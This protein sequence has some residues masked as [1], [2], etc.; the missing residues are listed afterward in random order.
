VSGASG[1]DP[2]RS[3]RTPFASMKSLMARMRSE[4]GFALLEAIVSA[5]V[6][7]MVALAVLAGIDGASASSG[8][9]KARNVAATLAESDQER[10]RATSVDDL[11]TAATTAGYYIADPVGTPV[12]SGGT[13]VGTIK[14]V[15]GVA[16]TVTSTAQF[17][18]DDS[19]GSASCSTDT[20]A[21]QYFHIRTTVTSAVVGTRLA[22]VT[23]DS[24]VAPNVAYSSTVG[25]LVIQVLD[26]SGN[27]VPNKSVTVS[28]GIGSKTTNSLGCVVFEQ[29]P[30][31]TGG[32]TY[33]ASLSDSLYVDHFGNSNS[34][35]DAPVLPNKVNRVTMYY[36]VAKA[37]AANIKTYAPG[38]TITA[39]GTGIPS[40]AYQ[41]SATNSGETGMLRNWPSAAGSSEFGAF[42]VDKQFPFPSAYT[43]FSGNCHYND[44]TTNTY[45]NTGT[46]IAG[47]LAGQQTLA[48]VNPTVYQPPLNAIIAKNSSNATPSAAMKVI[49]KAV[50]PNGDDCDQPTIT[51]STFKVGSSWMVG[52][53]VNASNQLDAGVPYGQY[54]LCFKDG[55]KYWSPSSYPNAAGSASYYDNTTPPTGQTTAE[56]FTP[57]G[58]SAWS[59]TASGACVP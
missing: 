52:R 51:L 20:K 17:V 33:Q 5:A 23:I 15:D 37:A 1:L 46:T 55:T 39:P 7:A 28:N 32:Q 42:T 12:L 26:A 41:V 57:S 14:T 58:S 56:S 13:R 29:V 18:A 22:P 27:P 8:R 50:T 54:T 21:T 24:I 44:P 30:T 6:L 11:A 45:G 2:N 3:T 47:L 59:S 36:D 4:S 48:G 10:L 49:V 38:S 35:V 43:F 19:G 31:V 34:T 16:Y 9:E 40:A 25:T 53:S